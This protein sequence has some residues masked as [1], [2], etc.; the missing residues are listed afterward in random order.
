MRSAGLAA[1]I[2]G[3]SDSHATL[4]MPSG[5]IRMVLVDCWA[6]VGVL[7]NADLKISLG[8]RLVEFVNLAGDLQFVV[9]R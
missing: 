3:K 5:E 7:G 8:V 1:Q 4:R 2:M 9:W 6:T